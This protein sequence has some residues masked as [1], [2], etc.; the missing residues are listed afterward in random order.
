MLAY[1]LVITESDHSDRGDL[2]GTCVTTATLCTTELFSPT[3]SSLDIDL[4][5]NDHN[6]C[7]EY[8]YVACV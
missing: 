2:L 8:A 5:G 3:S 6:V 4:S 7:W 1:L